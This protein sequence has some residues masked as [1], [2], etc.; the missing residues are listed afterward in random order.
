VTNNP[1]NFAVPS[2][3]LKKIL[4][5]SEWCDENF[6]DSSHKE[7]FWMY[8]VCC[9][10]TTTKPVL[11]PV[12]FSCLVVTRSSFY[13]CKMTTVW[14]LS[15]ASM[16]VWSLEYVDFSFHVSCSLILY[17]S[18][19]ARERS[20]QHLPPSVMLPLPTYFSVFPSSCYCNMLLV[21]AVACDKRCE[22]V[23]IGQG[24]LQVNMTECR[25]WEAWS[26]VITTIHGTSFHDLSMRN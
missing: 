23:D 3:A 10:G 21:T 7:H 5:G 13:R 25:E 8:A 15:F 14:G 11:S 6:Q 9:Q 18:T 16:Y 20:S 17:P 1:S 2:P 22:L 12:N 19:E 24:G 26:Y 4:C